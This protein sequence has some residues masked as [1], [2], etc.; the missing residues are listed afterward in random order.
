[1]KYNPFQPNAIVAPGMF[2]GR[3][4]EIKVIE[5]CLFQ[6]KSGNPQHFLVQGE[7]GIGKSSLLFLV[8]AIG[9]GLA[10]TVHSNEQL[11][12][13]TLFVDLGGVQ[14]QLISCVVLL[15]S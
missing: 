12:F 4:D 9:S 6:T 13:L 10:T 2:I 8:E 14:K 3:A 7:R 15:E 11:S 5:Q 1:M